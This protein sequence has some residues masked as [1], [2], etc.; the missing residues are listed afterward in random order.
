[1]PDMSIR[2][3]GNMVYNLPKLESQHTMPEKVTKDQRFD[4]YK[5]TKALDV[6]ALNGRHISI[7]HEA[8]AFE[9]A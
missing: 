9:E 5:N 2:F 3:K 7:E 8:F 1:M 4:T 6:K